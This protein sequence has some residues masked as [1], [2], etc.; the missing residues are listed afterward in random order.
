MKKIALLVVFIAATQIFAGCEQTQPNQPAPSVTG[1][2]NS[3][4]LAETTEYSNQKCGYKLTFPED[5]LGYYYVQ[6]NDNGNATVIFVGKSKAYSTQLEDI[7]GYVGREIF[8]IVD[9]ETVNTETLDSRFKIGTAK[10]V[11]YYYATGTSAAFPFP[12]GPTEDYYVNDDGN[13]QN[14]LDDPL[15]S[16]DNIKAHDMFKEIPAILK[17]FTSTNNS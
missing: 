14:S 1:N 7:T 12:Y 17:T 4:K 5:W 11:N 10:G 9:E 8:Y 15:Y 16:E 2:E 6:E 13:W 3:V